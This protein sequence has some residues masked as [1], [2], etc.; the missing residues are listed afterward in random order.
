[1]TWRGFFEGLG[2][3]FQWTFGAVEFLGNYANIF[4]ILVMTIMGVYWIGQMF[5]H[6]RRGEN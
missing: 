3:F 4:F 2:D 6:Q 5:G 1:M